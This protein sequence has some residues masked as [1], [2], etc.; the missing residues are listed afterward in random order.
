MDGG[1][2]PTSPEVGWAL[3]DGREHREPEYD[4]V[5]AQRLYE[6]LEQQVIPEF[7]DRD[8]AGMPHNLAQAYSSQH[9]TSDTAIQQ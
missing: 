2:R 9:G 3:G 4:A 7:Y 1:L 8:R 6:I 5:E